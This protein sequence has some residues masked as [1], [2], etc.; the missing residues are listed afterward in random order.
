MI[1]T[2]CIQNWTHVNWDGVGS[3]K[4]PFLPP[5]PLF[6]Q[7]PPP[8]LLLIPVFLCRR[9]NFSLET[10]PFLSFS[11]PRP[12]AKLRAEGDSHQT[13]AEK[14]VWGRGGIQHRVGNL[15]D[16]FVAFLRRFGR[17]DSESK[18]FLKGWWFS[19][20]PRSSYDPNPG[21]CALQKSTNFPQN[22]DGILSFFKFFL[23]TKPKNISQTPFTFPKK[24]G[25][26]PFFFLKLWR[27]SSS[28]VCEKERRRN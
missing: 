4:L 21:I 3:Q 12:S 24:S 25:V 15:F 28:A 7:T 13:P 20:P 5:N 18:H 1:D 10:I 2:I 14:V 9:Q 26:V 11:P 6:I 17:R 8:P 27:V 19:P 22:W 23:V 16:K